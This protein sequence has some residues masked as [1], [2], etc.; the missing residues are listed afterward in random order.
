MLLFLE[1][2]SKPVNALNWDYRDLHVTA[3]KKHFQDMKSRDKLDP[4]K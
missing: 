3:R 1:Q 2:N 4:I